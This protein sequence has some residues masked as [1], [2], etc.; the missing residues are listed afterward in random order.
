MPVTLKVE[1]S[2]DE[3]V[4]A[5][6]NLNERRIKTL[7][8][9]RVG[10]GMDRNPERYHDY[11]VLEQENEPRYEKEWNDGVPFTHRYGDDILIL[12]QKAITA[13]TEV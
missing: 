4:I 3:N 9:A 6:V 1:E 11:M 5:T 10:R 2:E 13:L 8:I 12:V 7:H